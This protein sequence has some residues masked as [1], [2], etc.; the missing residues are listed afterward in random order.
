MCGGG[1]VALIGVLV[2]MGMGQGAALAFFIT[3]PA[4]KISTIVSLQAV[5]RK[6]IALVYLTVTLIGGVLFGYGYSL[7]GLN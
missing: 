5:L 2:S 4:T 3:G 7:T 1:T 6:K